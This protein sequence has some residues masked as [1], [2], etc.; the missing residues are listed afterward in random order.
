MM[1]ASD[2]N[3]EQFYQEF[4]MTRGKFDPAEFGIRLSKKQFVDQMAEE[5]NE[6]YRGTWTVDELVLH[7]REAMKFCDEVRRKYHYYD[8]PDD[9]ILRVVMNRRKKP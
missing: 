5:F 1:R 4:L 9:I 2:L 8:L 6:T 7:P 3:Q